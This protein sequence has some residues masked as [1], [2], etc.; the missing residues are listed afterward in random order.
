MVTRA[1]NTTIQQ[2]EKDIAAVQFKGKMFSLAVLHIHSND[3]DAIKRQLAYLIAQAPKMFHYAPI[4]IDLEFSNQSEIGV[5]L[6]ALC[7]LL[8]QQLV[9]P[10]GIVGGTP[11]QQQ[12][13]A[14]AGLALFPVSKNAR[15]VN[16]KPATTP[17]LTT[18]SV[19]GA[20]KTKVISQPIRSGQQIYVKEGDLIVLASV[21]HGAEIIADGNIHVYGT[22][23]GRAIA[24][25]NGDNNA[26]IFCTKLDAELISIAGIY[27]LSDD[28]ATKKS[29]T[30]KQI[31][32]QNDRLLITDL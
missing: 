21:S 8:K 24:G 12:T 16:P 26:R 30:P 2:H 10:V 19:A 14:K 15:T 20:T 18:K 1:M 11:L 25:A 3:L 6:T 7:S 32:L 23:H 17:A 13:A 4:V 28:Y 5:E 31:F 9:I 22:L 27:S 29:D